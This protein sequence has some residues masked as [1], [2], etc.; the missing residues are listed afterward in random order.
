MMAK[1]SANPATLTPQPFLDLFFRGFFAPAA[2]WAVGLS[3]VRWTDAVP[4]LKQAGHAHVKHGEAA[5]VLDSVPCG[6]HV[7]QK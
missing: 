3:T 6:M 1:S 7:S 5:R 2:R 4:F